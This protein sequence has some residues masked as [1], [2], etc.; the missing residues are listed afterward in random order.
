MKGLKDHLLSGACS[1]PA[2]LRAL[3]DQAQPTTAPT[4]SLA[5]LHPRQQRLHPTLQTHTA[6]ELGREPASRE[7]LA[8]CLIWGFWTHDH[9]KIKS[10]IRQAHRALWDA[11]GEQAVANCGKAGLVLLKGQ[12]CPC[13]EKHVHDKR[14][15]PGQCPVLFQ[16]LFY[17]AAHS[18]TR[19][20][21]G[22]LR[23]FMPTA[24]RAPLPTA[25][26][27][28]IPASPAPAPHLGGDASST[29]SSE[30]RP[31]RNISN[32]CYVNSV[33]SALIPTGILN[34]HGPASRAL[35]REAS[36]HAAMGP[37]VLTASFSLRH[38]TPTWRY[39]GSQ[40]DAS[41]YLTA[42]FRGLSSFPI[43]RP[44]ETKDPETGSTL[45][46]GGPLLLLPTPVGQDTASLQDLL[47]A[48]SGTPAHTAL[49]GQQSLVTVAVARFVEGRKLHYTL[50]GL[51][52]PISIPQWT[53]AGPAES[54]RGW[55]QSCIFHIGDGPHSGHYRCIWRKTSDDNWQSTDD[56]RSSVAASE[57]DMR[58]ARNGGYILLV[59]PFLQDQPVA[60]PP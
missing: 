44:W 29:F 57:S 26:P 5:G 27:P 33:I 45:D 18:L 58:Q 23:R 15:H 6:V 46:R 11:H 21:G 53:P 41:E 50:S 9:G 40:Q 20:R 43:S 32:F 35:H 22:P 31:L 36:G 4:S 12:S 3:D 19:C 42:L 16:I 24:A 59:R 56:G 8:Y 34:D 39:G 28:S 17:D 38:V 54:L 49:N 60:G 51:H 2:E 47:D 37:H 30:P 13:C 52:R 48:W 55:V 10:H 14:L 1:A 25:T 7:L